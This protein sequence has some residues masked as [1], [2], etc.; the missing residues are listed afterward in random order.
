M[1]VLVCQ[2]KGVSVAGLVASAMG[3]TAIYLLGATSNAGLNSKGAYLL[4]WTMIG[5]LKERG[6]K[7]YDL[8]GIDPER[9]PGVYSFKR[10]FS[11]ADLCQIQPRAASGSA[12]SSGFVKAGLALRRARHASFRPLNFSRWLKAPAATR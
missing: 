4:Q 10:G 11:G 8:G 7:A 3:D 6:I 5:W 12:V 2:D 9:N 1:Q